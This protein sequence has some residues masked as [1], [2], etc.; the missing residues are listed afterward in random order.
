MISGELLIDDG[1][2]PFNS[3]RCILIVVVHNTVDRLIQ[4]GSY[5]Y[6]VEINGVFAFDCE[7]ARGMRLNIASGMVVRFESG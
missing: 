6:F 1:E 7:V 5:Y 4:V 3:D 2:H